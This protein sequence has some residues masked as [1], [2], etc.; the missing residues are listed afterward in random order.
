MNSPLGSV[1]K[2]SGLKPQ[3]GRSEGVYYSFR[4]LRDHTVGLYM[5]L[6]FINGNHSFT[7]KNA[8]WGTIMCEALSFIWDTTWKQQQSP[9][10]TETTLQKGQQPAVIVH[11][12]LRS[13]NTMPLRE[14]PAI[15][16]HYDVLTQVQVSGHRRYF[17]TSFY[18]TQSSCTYTC[19]CNLVN[20]CRFLEVT[21]PKMWPTEPWQSSTLQGIKPY[22]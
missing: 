19:T 6:N 3:V 10:L 15:W 2:I 11:T 5:L 20:T 16:L 7:K 22:S 18:H 8:C 13:P 4:V 14:H 21:I 12:P 1:L 17:W 9:A